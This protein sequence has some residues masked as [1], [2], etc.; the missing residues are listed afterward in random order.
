[1]A[2]LNPDQPLLVQHHS[3]WEST[4]TD[5]LA[6]VFFGIS[7]ALLTIALPLVLYN[8]CRSRRQAAQQERLEICAY[9][10]LAGAEWVK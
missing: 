2:P 3:Y 5:V 1:M 9:V 4:T 6:G 10:E 7:A 8:Y